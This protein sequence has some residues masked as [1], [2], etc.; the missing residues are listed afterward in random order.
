MRKLDAKEDVRLGGLGHSGET[1]LVGSNEGCEGERSPAPECCELPED[2]GEKPPMTLRRRD[3]FL[4]KGAK[5]GQIPISDL[6]ADLS[7]VSGRTFGHSTSSLYR[8]CNYPP[9]RF[10][11]SAKAVEV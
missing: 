1:G 4:R 9:M 8:N 10:F 11:D 2:A 5:D 7:R 6:L 3:G